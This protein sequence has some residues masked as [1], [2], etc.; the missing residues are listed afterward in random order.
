[1]RRVHRWQSGLS[2]LLEAYVLVERSTMPARSHASQVQNG[3]FAEI[4]P[5]SPIG[6]VES[7]SAPLHLSDVPFSRCKGHFRRPWILHDKTDG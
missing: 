5:Q 3:D 2:A 6:C 7:L 4:C 1:M